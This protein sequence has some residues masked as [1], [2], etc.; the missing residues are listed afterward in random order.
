MVARAHAEAAASEPPSRP[1]RA[2]RVRSAGP[3]LLAAALATVAAIL[4]Y[5]V[6]GTATGASLDRAGVA[7][8]DPA[9]NPTLHAATSELLHTISV[10]SLV[11]LG[12]AIIAL[13]LLARGIWP[14][15]AAAALILGANVTTQ[16]LK[17]ALGRLDPVGGETVRELSSSFPS[18]HA[19]VAMSLGL[20]LVLVVPPPL[21]RVAAILG[22]GYAAGIGLALLSLGWHYP[23]DVAGAYLVATAWACAVAAAPRLVAWRP[24]R[25]VPRPATAAGIRAAATVVGVAALAFV[26]L[27]AVA[28]VQRPELVE[29]ARIR[30]LF[31]LAAGLLVA[32][33]V[34]LFG[35]VTALL[36]RQPAPAGP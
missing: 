26:V 21:A 7:P 33:S 29:L 9:S 32:L 2:E 34:V 27:V 3:F 18:G 12:T 31:F 36:A 30:T 8:L 10:D 17:P 23:S 19:T 4:V 1:S 15:A 22:A 5:A 11:L 20:A 16:L 35:A 14:A 6:A 25:R 24:G 13:G 28:V